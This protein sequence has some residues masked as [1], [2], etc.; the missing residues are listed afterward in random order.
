MIVRWTLKELLR[1]RTRVLGSIAAVGAAF[2]LVIMFRAVWEGESRQIVVYL[3][4]AGADVWVMQDHVSN[5]H[6]ASSFVAEGKRNEIALVNGVRSVDAILYLNTMVE[7]GGRQ[8][9]SYVVGVEEPGQP[10]G[11]WSLAEGRGDVTSGE[12]VIP[13]TLARLTDVG[14]GDSIRV[15]DRRFEIVGLSNQ[16]FSVTNPVIFVP[17]ADLADL[18]SLSGYDSYML[19]DAEPGVSAA[20]LAARIEE[21]VDGVAALTTTDFVASDL[22]LAS[23][24]GTEVI[25]LMTAI[26]AALAAVLVA[27]ALFIHTSHTR[28]ELVILKAVGFSNRH[29]YLSVLLQAAILTGLAFALAVAFVAVTSVVGPRLAPILSLSVSAGSIAQIGLAGLL[30]ALAATLLLARRVAAVDPMSAFSE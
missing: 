29:M 10:G 24:M 2:A 13:A 19:V 14:I 27:F 6:M 21:E 11:P 15:A 26:C 5:M 9:F 22:Q 8:W 18:L 7:S 16:T 17:A 12:A 23:Q 25:A 1:S 3:E 30:V 20:E 4:H 28:R